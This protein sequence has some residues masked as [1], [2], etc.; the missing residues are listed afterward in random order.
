VQRKATEFLQSWKLR[1]D[2]KPLV[3]RGARQVGKTWLMREFGKNSFERT[4]YINFENNPRMAALFSGTFD[5]DSLLLGLQIETGTEIIPGKTLLIFDEVQ[6]VP[7]AL[8]SLK[9]FQEGEPGIPIIAAGS[10]LG[11]AMH[12]GTSFPV[13]KV[14]FLDLFPMSFPEF[15]LASGQAP[16]HDAIENLDFDL[17]NAFASTLKDLLKQYLF[18]GGMPE[19][20]NSFVRSKD[21]S[22]VRKIQLDLLS[23]YEQDF[24][25]HAPTSDVPRIRAVWNSLP[26]QLARENRKFIYGLVRTGARAREYELAIQWLQDCGLIHKVHRISKP[27]IPL[28]AYRDSAAFKLYANDVGLLCAS[29]ALDPETLLRGNDLFTEFKGAV[30]EQF[31]LQQLISHAGLK[32]YYWSSDKGSAEVDFVMETDQKVFPLEVKAS[33]NLQAKSLKTFETR[34]NP[35][36][37][38]RTSLSPFRVQERLI[39]VPLYAVHEIASVIAGNCYSKED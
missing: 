37:S 19:A 18:V 39:N 15:F 30:T 36:T 11:V 28:S 5:L 32:P 24:S 35:G 14:E 22:R 4:A 31:V 29:G 2:R 25:K 8:T 34:Y 26:A 20:V 7:S 27:G 17:T 38:F 3:I 23:A 9:Y 13:G 6:E 21:L 33:E 12:S 16:L 1:E 10:L